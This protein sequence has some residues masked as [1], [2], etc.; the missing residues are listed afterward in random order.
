[1]FVKSVKLTLYRQP[2]IIIDCVSLVCCVDELD[3]LP[4][5]SRVAI[6]VANDI[7]GVALATLGHP[8]ESPLKDTSLG[9]AGT[10]HQ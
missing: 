8:L 1:M 6:G 2:A 9:C 7:S 5:G 10:H 3:Q 4:I